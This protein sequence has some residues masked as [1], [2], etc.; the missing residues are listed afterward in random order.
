MR[1]GLIVLFIMFFGVQLCVFVFGC[2]YSN[3]SSV[4]AMVL[5]A[6]CACGNSW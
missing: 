2:L 4:F 6:T 3:D 1:E 5:S